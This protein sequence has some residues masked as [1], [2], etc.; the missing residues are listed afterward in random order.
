MIRATSLTKTFGARR[1]VDDVSFDVNSGEIF[2]FL[3]PNGAGKTTTILM[4]MGILEPDAGS[5]EVAGRRVARGDLAARRLIGAVSEQPHLHDDGTVDDYLRFFARLYEVEDASARI[6]TLLDELGIA[7]RRDDRPTHLSKGLQQKLSFARALLH[8]PP[9]L[10]LDEP[11]SG[12]DPNGIR[13]FRE[14][15]LRERERGRCILL[16]SHVLSEV[17][18]TA[19]RVGILH[20][21]R[22]LLVSATGEITA[23]LGQTLDVEIEIEGDAAWVLDSVQRI[24]GVHAGTAEGRRL[25]LSLD[26]AS[27]ARRDVARALA[28]AGAVVL[29][30]RDR[31]PS[32]EEAFVTLTAERVATL[33]APDARGS[34]A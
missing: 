34:G 14:V 6:A 28:A 19:D 5:A 24:A 33:A 32:L 25:S 2:G 3:G 1:A 13:E 15:L 30:M 17:E 31:A 18:R 26:P 23:R 10:I 12:L 4:L 20:G 8:D 21:G 16:S 11:I 27:D 22:M 7:D 29:Q 9:V